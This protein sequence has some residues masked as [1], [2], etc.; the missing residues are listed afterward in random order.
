MQGLVYSDQGGGSDPGL[1]AYRDL[2]KNINKQFEEAQKEEYNRA[3]STVASLIDSYHKASNSMT[4]QEDI[5]DMM[6]LYQSV[7]PNH[8]KVAVEPYIAHGPTNPMAEKRRQF[9]QMFKRPQSPKFI[10]GTGESVDIQNKMS[11]GQYWFQKADWEH[12]LKTFMAGAEAAGD[13]P[14]FF[15]YG[16]GSGIMRDKKGRI[17]Y[18][19]KTD[20]DLK[21][22]EEKYGV[23]AREIIM[24][25]EGIPTGK[26]TFA[27]INGQQIVYEQ[28]LKPLAPAGEQYGQRIAAVN[29]IPSSALH[30][31]LPASL[32]KLILDWKRED[33]NDDLVKEYKDRLDKVRIQAEKPSSKQVQAWQNETINISNDLSEAYHGYSFEI[34]DVS[35]DEPTWKKLLNWLPL[36]SADT[37]YAII[38]I[39]GVPIGLTDASGKTYTYYYDAPTDMVYD[40]SGRPKGTLQ[41]VTAEI[42]SKTVSIKP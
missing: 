32:S 21:N 39:K 24:N 23:T 1:S 28:T 16:D 20:M 2:Y 11:L 19:S 6:K 8:L 31:Q 3:K 25:P 40:I 27:N 30:E 29:A 10:E 38:P 22:L 4:L 15:P 36:V 33:P 9:E 34:R 7:I 41:Q 35:R 5:V 14:Y 18:L 26:K 17:T 12:A 42:A 13:K 37:K